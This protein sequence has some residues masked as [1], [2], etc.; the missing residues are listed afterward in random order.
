MKVKA[1]GGIQN[2]RSLF[3]RGSSCQPGHQ[4]THRCMA[5]DN[6]II[7]CIDDLL[8]FAVRSSIR[9]T[10]RK[11]LKRHIKVCIAVRNDTL[12]GIV[13]VI[14]RCDSSFSSHILKKLQTGHV[15]GH[16]MT[17]DYLRN[18]QYLFHKCHSKQKLY[19][20]LLA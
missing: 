19:V 6:V 17:S 8:Q 5:V 16:D 7:A 11:A 1:V 3:P 10:K 9:R 2:L 15:E 13:I 12:L 4:A 18:E 14:V 20:I